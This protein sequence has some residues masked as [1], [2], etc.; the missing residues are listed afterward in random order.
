[1]YILRP[2]DS[3]IVSPLDSDR[4]LRSEQSSPHEPGETYYGISLPHIR[5]L[6]SRL[7]RIAVS[8]GT[9]SATNLL[10]RRGNDQPNNA[11]I[12]AV[13][14]VLLLVFLAG[15]C[16]F[17]WIYRHSIRFSGRK[18]HRRH[19]KSSGSKSSEGEGKPPP[20]S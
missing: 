14:A 18:K 20:A 13:V 12:G 17:L 6:V 19:H 2:K 11:I 5:P 15:A 9:E 3:L 4:G 16:A 8:A 1:M 7:L 10:Q